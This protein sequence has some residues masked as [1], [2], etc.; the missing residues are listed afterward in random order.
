MSSNSKPIIAVTGAT[1]AQ[2]G[3]VVRFLLKDGGFR[4]RALTRNVDSDTA[5]A[6]KE[7][8]VEVVRA[9][10]NDLKSL[11]DA[12]KGVHGVFGVTNYWDPAVF[13]EEKEFVQGKLLVDAAKAAGVKHFVFSTLEEWN[14]PPVEHFNAKSRINNYLIESGVPRTSVYTSFYFENFTNPIM[15]LAIKKE[16]GYVA[17]WPTLWSDGPIPGYAVADTGAWV[18]A[19]FKDPSR[20]VG[21]DIKIITEIFT[22][23]QFV[24]LVEEIG[25]KKIEMKETSYEKFD[26]M[27]NG[28]LFAAEL[29]GKYV[30]ASS[31]SVIFLMLI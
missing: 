6:L 21:Q 7:K 16:N 30:F 14:A 27:K 11:E 20:F 24:A 1:G 19:A 3:S 4:I 29:H 12:F 23:R 17:E 15:G 18:L 25:G 9:D 31:F 26:E 28:G 5:K 10:L 2:G 13:N 22:P 8:G